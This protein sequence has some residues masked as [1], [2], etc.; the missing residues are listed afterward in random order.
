MVG[1][2]NKK[3]G[4]TGGR[5][6]NCYSA[7]RVRRS[8]GHFIAG[9]GVTSIASFAVAILL[10]RMMP[11]Q[12]YAG[13]TA[14]SGL[15]MT[16]MVISNGGIER[17]VPRY[18][19]E[20]RLKCADVELRRFCWQLTRLRLSLLL[21]ILALLV[22]AYPYARLWLSIPDQPLMLSA[23]FCYVLTYGMSMHLN[24]AMQSLMLQ[25]R[26]T[27]AM[28]IE[29]FSK[30]ALVGVWFSFS[31]TINLVKAVWIQGV[32]AGF[33]I[34]YMVYQLNRHLPS[35][36]E[37]ETTKEVLDYQQVRR[38]GTHNYLQ[39]LAGFH[40]DPAVGKMLSSYFLP[41]AITA[42]LGFAHS[43]AGVLRRYLPA[44]LL[45]GLIEPTIMAKHSESNDFSKTA[46]LAA[47]V[48]KMNLFILVP[49]AIFVC[50]SGQPL[51]EIITG[52][53]YGDSAW[54]ISILLLV[55]M[56][57]SHRFVLQLIV[58]AVEK[59]ELLLTS[60][61]WSLLFVPVTIAA[62][63]LFGIK[64]L[65]A[66]VLFIS[67]SRNFYLVHMLRKL[68]LPYRPDWY[69][70]AK[71]AILSAGAVISAKTF[72]A[73]ELA[74]VPEALVAGTMAAIFF[75]LFAFV[76]KP[77]SQKERDTL[78]RFLGRPCFVW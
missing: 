3:T 73:N 12:D 14:L 64:G 44:T 38:M 51:V 57:E 29:W 2:G 17:I 76:W 54:L 62:I 7:N 32:T 55:L 47:I 42:S 58:N 67:F 23:F 34:I 70:V 13:Y 56:M 9:R 5:G 16:L 25:R 26:A 48:F 1:E 31:H 75:L 45:L 65:M 66:G 46:H 59:S 50:V 18:F 37:G 68:G 21:A 49:V 33:G 10:V 35:I 4:V 63:F 71:I 11:V 27:I 40:A 22:V 19:P 28:A 41:E 30:L 20:L 61:L 43:I 6:G 53:K 60:N 74:P 52:G 39:A 24:R 72:V 36:E 77:F 15:L 8:L 69:G 78:N